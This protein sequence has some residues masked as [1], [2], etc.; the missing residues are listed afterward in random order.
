MKHSLEELPEAIGMYGIPSISRARV[1]D[2]IGSF[3]SRH[4]SLQMRVRAP[5]HCSHD[6]SRCK[7]RRCDKRSALGIGIQ[8]YTMQRLWAKDKNTQVS[9]SAFAIVRDSYWKIRRRED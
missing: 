2:D 7:V 4:S 6:T 3:K 5:P 9:V 8:L 1:D